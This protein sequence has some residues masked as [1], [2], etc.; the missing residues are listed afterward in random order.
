MSTMRV[1]W[2]SAL[3][4]TEQLAMDAARS[5]H[6]WTNRRHIYQAATADIANYR[7]HIAHLIH[8]ETSHTANATHS[9]TLIYEPNSPAG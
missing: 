4:C 6:C 2:S 3:R 5:W 8:L 7:L 9:L 1:G